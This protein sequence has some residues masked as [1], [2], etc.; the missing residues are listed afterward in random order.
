MISAT[1]EGEENLILRKIDIKRD[2]GT[3]ESYILT[4]ELENGETVSAR[5]AD[6][7][8]PGA[9]AALEALDEADEKDGKIVGKATIKG[10]SKPFV[11]VAGFYDGKHSFVELLKGR[12]KV[13][14]TVLKYSTSD[15]P[16]LVQRVRF[17]HFNCGDL[18]IAGIGPLFR[19]LHRE[20]VA[21]VLPLQKSLFGA[22]Q[23]SAPSDVTPTKAEPAEHAV[24]TVEWLLD[25]TVAHVKARVRKL[26]DADLLQ[27]ARAA[28]SRAGVHQVIDAR[29]DQLA[30]AEAESTPLI[31]HINPEH[32][33]A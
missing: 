24:G 8:V 29:L 12:A 1:R 30:K 17:E 9:E 25:G 16:V 4:L 10:D 18:D 33:A 26:D 21:Q 11:M 15:P 23:Q 32:V 27:R 7:S 28:D 31:G 5:Q 3:E 2:K 22:V 19:R 14:H 13:I 20:L 6:I